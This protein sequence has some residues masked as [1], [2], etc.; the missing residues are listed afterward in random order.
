MSLEHSSKIRSGLL[1]MMAIMLIGVLSSPC[2]AEKRIVKDG[3]GEVTII[4][5]ELDP[6]EPVRV[7]STTIHEIHTDRLIVADGFRN[8]M[9]VPMTNK[10][11]VVLDTSGKE[12]PFEDLKV[13]DQVSINEKSGVMTIQKKEDSN[14]G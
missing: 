6:N 2:M 3:E 9:A 1:V 10:T 11:V 14:E 4:I 8:L 13:M 7:E 12:I 5:R